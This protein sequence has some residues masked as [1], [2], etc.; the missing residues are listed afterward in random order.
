MEERLLEQQELF[1]NMILIQFK[2]DNEAE[3][4][5]LKNKGLLSHFIEK[6]SEQM[7]DELR[8]ILSSTDSSD[9]QSFYEAVEIVVNHHIVEVSMPYSDDV[10]QKD[11]DDEIETKQFTSDE[12]VDFLYPELTKSLYLKNKWEILNYREYGIIFVDDYLRLIDIDGYLSIF[13]KIEGNSLSEDTVEIELDKLEN[14][15]LYV[16]PKN[17]NIVLQKLS[18]D[19]KQ[20]QNS[21]YSKAYA[22]DRKLIWLI[23]WSLVFSIS[24][25]FNFHINFQLF[26]LTGIL[27]IGYELFLEW[28]KK[29]LRDKQIEVSSKIY[30]L[31]QSISWNKCTHTDIDDLVSKKQ[32]VNLL[33]SW[34]YGI[35]DKVDKAIKLANS[36]N[37]I[38]LK[39]NNLYENID[40]TTNNLKFEVSTLQEEQESIKIKIHK[41]SEELLEN[42]KKDIV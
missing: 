13:K 41:I 34:P 1:K 24:I 5:E 25:Y 36:L 29:K 31:I 27:V 9:I 21:I 39:L 17:Y 12:I 7:I 28:K 8:T 14:I 30:K 40:S 23:I 15:V 26:F 3:Y 35:E 33:F 4:I 18:E 11:S 19:E 37:L 10:F 20:Q 22:L 42:F 2:D 38:N 6:K 16:N 32:Q